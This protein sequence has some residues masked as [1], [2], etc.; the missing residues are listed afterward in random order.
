M[1][2]QHKG[3]PGYLFAVALAVALV[4]PA[5]SAK[6]KGKR[7]SKVASP[8]S[9]GMSSE[10][11]QEL[12]ETFSDYVREGE[13]AGAVVRVMRRGQTVFQQ[14]WGSRDLESDDPL[15]ATDIFRIAS[16]TKAIVSVAIMMLQEDGELLISDPV[17][18]YLPAF[19]DS[20]VA[21]SLEGDSYGVVPASREITLR[22]LLTHTA[23]VSYGSGP[24]ASGSGKKP[25]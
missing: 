15:E 12:D 11:L 8:E 21:V 24:A 5:A 19:K 4:A 13:L 16:Q 22:D 20:T 17:S 2:K 1:N 25:A 3:L 14:A 6:G 23:G 7:D 18:R 9:V 10:R